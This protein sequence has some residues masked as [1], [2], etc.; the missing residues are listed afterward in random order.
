MKHLFNLKRL[1][2]VALSSAMGLSMAATAAP[3]VIQALAADSTATDNDTATT[4]DLDDSDI[5]DTS[6][7]GSLTI[8]K[9]DI[10]AAEAAYEGSDGSQGYVAGSITATGEEDTDLQDT[11]A[12][13]AIEGVQF[14]YLKCGEIETYSVSSGSGSYVQVV[15]EI[16]TGLAEILGLDEDDAFDVSES[17]RTSATRCSNEGVLHYTSTQIEDALEAILEAD[18]VDAKNALE[19]YVYTYNTQDS[20]QDQSVD[21]AENGYTAVNMDKTDENGYTYVEGLELGLYLIVETE[22]PEQVTETV[23]PWFVSIPFTDSDGD[24]WLYDMYCY[25]KNQTGNPTL[26]KSVRNAYTNTLASSGAYDKNAIETSLATGDTYDGSSSSNSLIVWNQDDSNED[27]DT[28]DATYVANRGGYT[29]D[30][31]TAGSGAKEDISS[32]FTYADTTTA[33]EGDLLDYILVSKLPHISSTATYLSEYTFVDELGPGI[34]YN[35][36]VKIAFYH[37]RADAEANNTAKAD[38]IWGVTDSNGD[39]EYHLDEYADVTVV[40]TDSGSAESDGSTR[41]TVSMTEKGLNLI[42]CGEWTDLQEG[43]TWY[44]LSDYYMVVYYT[45]TVNSDA[46]CV[47]GDEG[48]QN[49]VSLIWSRTS[50]DYYNTLEDTNFVYSY[51]I[52]LTKEFEDA[53]EEDLAGYLSQVEFKLYNATDGYYVVAEQKSEGVYYVTGKTVAGDDDGKAEA[54]TFT[55]A[56]DGTLVINGLEADTYELTE[57]STASGYTLLKDQIEITI[58]STDRDIIASV[59][60]VTGL[61]SE[62]ADAIIENYHGGIYDE[63]GNLINDQSTE[64]EKSATTDINGNTVS[65]GISS[66]DITYSADEDANGR[67]INGSD[68]YVGAILPATATVDGVVSSMDDWDICVNQTTYTKNGTSWVSNNDTTLTATGDVSTNAAVKLTVV[69]NKN[70]LLPQTGGAGLYLITIIGVVVAA[71]GIYIVTRK[72]KITPAQ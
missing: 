16:P 20:N 44:G 45:A 27:V 49:S 25:P 42:N 28:N 6:K 31:T 60:G 39:A 40:N 63:N 19:D 55:P 64:L 5:I 18:N 17:N 26:D 57:V 53:D 29:D 72:K 52:D 65:S 7:T 30:G 12:D 46:T 33:S 59:A 61:T 14:T 66:T 8:Y 36:D 4:N 23:N 10:T 34:T 32:D 54:T 3:A 13:Y 37:T 22:V 71:G 58:T 43:E 69:N 35:N 62:Q 68:L 38:L 9:Y 48:N 51:A 11:L 1:G 67:T 24:E 70:F 15:Y 47:L 50:Y 21:T 41:L 56:S 2:A